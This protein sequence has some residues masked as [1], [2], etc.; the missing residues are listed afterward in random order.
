LARAAALA[1]AAEATEKAVKQADAAK[2]AQ[3]V[4]AV[5]QQVSTIV[6]DMATSILPTTYTLVSCCE[7]NESH[8]CNSHHKSCT[9]QVSLVAGSKPLS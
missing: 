6:Y 2:A 7:V 4:E 8:M 3:L 5:K 1:A 9:M